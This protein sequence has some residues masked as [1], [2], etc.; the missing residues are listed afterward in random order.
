[1]RVMNE[2]WIK[3]TGFVFALFFLILGYAKDNKEFLVISGIFLAVSLFVP[4]V[5]YPVAYLWQKCAELLGMIIP[6]I[7]FG[8][9]FFVIILPM[10]IFRRITKGDTLFVSN[11]RNSKTVFIN[12]NHLFNKQDLE[13]PY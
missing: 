13:N 1:M 8:L 10:G 11:W 12:R 5:I 3:D 6:K 4:I 2:K 7:F 9:V